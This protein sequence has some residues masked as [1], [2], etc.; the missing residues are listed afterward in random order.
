MWWALLPKTITLVTFVTVYSLF[1]AGNAC[2]IVYSWLHNAPKSL[3]RVEFWSNVK[4]VQFT[5]NTHLG[6]VWI[7]KKGDAMD[8]K[9]LRARYAFR[10]S[11][12]NAWEM[13]KEGQ[14][15][16]GPH[17]EIITCLC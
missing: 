17:V 11:V 4:H 13:L 3:R 14:M 10:R 5:D 15:Q 2:S 7:E 16:S 12:D 1:P 9:T 8:A 6:R